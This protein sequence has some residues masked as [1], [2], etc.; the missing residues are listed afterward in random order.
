MEGLEDVSKY[1]VLFD[2]LAERGWS[3]NE[4]KQLAGQNLLRV[5]KDVENVRD[6]LKNTKPYEK[7]IPVE[8]LR[9]S[10]QTETCRSDFTRAATGL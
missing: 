5:F 8:D 7:I 2:K 6:S 10:Q 9:A 3:K 1:P 4:L